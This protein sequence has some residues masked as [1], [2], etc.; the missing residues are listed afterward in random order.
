[1]LSEEGS[2]WD[3]RELYEREISCK[4]LSNVHLFVNLLCIYKELVIKDINRARSV[5]KAC[6]E[7]I[8]H[9]VFTFSNIWIMASKLEMR[10]K[11]VVQARKILGVALGK[12]P[13]DKLLKNYIDIEI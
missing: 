4:P 2:T 1:M 5:Y 11:T 7:V 6:L 9:K 12:C 13:K 8:P 10:Q 3:I